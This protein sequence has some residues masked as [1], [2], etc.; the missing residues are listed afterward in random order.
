MIGVPLGTADLEVHQPSLPGLSF[1][2]LITRQFLPGYF[3][4][5]LTALIL[6]ASLWC[7]HTRRAQAGSRLLRLIFLRKQVF[8]QQSQPFPID[9]LVIVKTAIMLAR[10]AVD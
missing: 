3:Q 9:H 4:S 6:L 7:P 2:P 5:R 1:I 8:A 10:T